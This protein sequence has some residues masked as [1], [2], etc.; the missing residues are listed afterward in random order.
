[1]NE[2]RP[3][4]LQRQPETPDRPP[5]RGRRGSGRAPL[6]VWLPATLV[7]AAV[8]LTPLYLVVRATDGGAEVWR[9]AIE[10]NSLR[11]LGQT[12]LLAVSVTAITVVLGVSIAFLTVRTDL[13][14]RRSLGVIAALPLVIPTFVGAY[15]LLAAV[16]RGGLLENWL[17]GAG[18]EGIRLPSPY[19]FWGAFVSL[20]LFTYPYVL[21]TVQGALRGIDP[22]LEEASRTLGQDGWATFRR[23]TLPQLRPATAAGALLVALYVLSDFGAVS[24]MRYSTFTRAIYL[25]Y[26][27][28]FDRTPAAVLGL[29]LVAMTVA[30][31][32]VEMRVG[33]VRRHTMASRRTTAREAPLLPLGRWRW[34]AA[35]FVGA[36]VVVALVLPLSVVAWWFVRGLQSGQEVGV[37]LAAARNSLQASALGAVASVL[38][39]LPIA[40]WAARYPGRRGRLVERAA[41][42]GYALPGIVVAL[43]LVFFGARY[44]GPLYQTQ[45]LLVFAYVVLFLPQAVGAIRTSLLQI[46][47]SMEEAA[48]TLGSRPLGALV[49]VIVPLARR[50]A[51]SGGALVFLTVMKEL[52]A[53]LL[54]APTGFD[55]LATRVWTTTSEAFFARASVPAAGLIVLGSLPLA[56]L[57]IAERRGAAPR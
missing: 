39:A 25:Q 8:L 24:L 22:A 54:L 3:T 18:L 14:G 26:Q 20:S 5:R 53:T 52:P 33:R 49:R 57:V 38:A 2:P 48:R 15:T 45:A 43:S 46:P 28:A 32:A 31:L 42:T 56:L 30:V 27:A 29:M 11:L 35:A 55:T 41:F 36:V 44:A 37:T 9:I 13:P 51:W 4:L 47:P 17:A 19:G 12:V 50:G 16:G 40:I 6:S 21:L 23:V 34:P 7:A 10:G 1:M